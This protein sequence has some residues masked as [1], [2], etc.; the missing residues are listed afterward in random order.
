MYLEKIEGHRKGSSIFCGDEYMYSKNNEYKNEI[1][2]RC[3]LYK[4]EC[5]GTAYIEFEKFFNIRKHNAQKNFAEIEKKTN[6]VAKIKNESEA[7][8]LAP[9]DIYNN[10]IIPENVDVSTFWKKSSIMRIRRANNS[11]LFPKKL[12]TL[13]LGQLIV[14]SFTEHSLPP[15]MNSR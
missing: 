13:I 7:S 9:R 5:S 15:T 2:L 10:N 3:A 14:I 6:I 8:T 4:K 12:K 1:N 11:H